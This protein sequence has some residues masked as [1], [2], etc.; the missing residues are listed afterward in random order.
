MLIF[1]AYARAD[2]QVPVARVVS[3]HILPAQYNDPR[4]YIGPR[5]Y[6]GPGRYNG[7]RLGMSYLIH[8]S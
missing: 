4:R 5:R 3:R 2:R 8:F 7:P 6:N 1:I